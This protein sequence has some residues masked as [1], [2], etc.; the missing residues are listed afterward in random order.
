[1]AAAGKPEISL[2]MIF[3]GDGCGEAFHAF[4]DFDQAFFAFT[5]LAAGSWNADTEVIGIIEEGTSGRDVA[6]R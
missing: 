6:I 2:K 1:M 5:L 3:L 4:G